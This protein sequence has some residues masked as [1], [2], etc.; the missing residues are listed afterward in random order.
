MTESYYWYEQTFTGWIERVANM[1]NPP[2]VNSISYGSVEIGYNAL[3]MNSFNTE[4]GKLGL[5][6]VSI[7]VSSGDD[8]V[9]NF[10][11]ACSQNGGYVPS[12]PATSP[13]VTAV[14][15]TQGPEASLPEMVCSSTE[16]GVITSGGGFSTHFPRP[17]YQKDGVIEEYFN[18]VTPQPLPGF[19]SSN[20]GYPDVSIIGVRY[21][22]V[23]HG[24]VALVYG[25]SCSAPVFSAMVSLI[26]GKRMEQNMSALG[27]L[28]YAL[29]EAAANASTADMFNDILK[30]NNSCCAS[31]EP[32]YTCCSAGFNAAPGWDPTNGLGSVDYTLFA[33]YVGKVDVGPMPDVDT[34]SN[35]DDFLAFKTSNPYVVLT[36][37]LMAVAAALCCFFSFCKTFSGGA[38]DEGARAPLI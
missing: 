32:P 2:L 16:G 3:L 34:N 37:V 33:K 13:Y 12:F 14:G 24:Q 36:I 4:A 1:E 17:D 25:T 29:Y 27:F 26:N 35:D 8:G 7:I 21:P 10:D 28:N 19:N 31:S 5:R 22:I 11:C 38:K 15:A 20:R 9:S 6:G 18:V 23:V 30:G